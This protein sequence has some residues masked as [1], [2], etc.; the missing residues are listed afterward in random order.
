MFGYFGGIATALLVLDLAGR[1]WNEGDPFVSR[2]HLGMWFFLFFVDFFWDS[3]TALLPFLL[4]RRAFG[5]GSFWRSALGGVATCGLTLLINLWIARGLDLAPD[6]NLPYWQALANLPLRVWPF[7]VLAGTTGGLAYW[8]IERNAPLARL[9]AF[10][11]RLA[12]A[13]EALDKH[14]PREVLLLLARWIRRRALRIAG[15]A[16]VVTLIVH[17]W[18]LW[19][20]PHVSW[21]SLGSSGAGI[22]R[23]RLLHEI[24][25]PDRYSIVNPIWAPSGTTLAGYTQGEL[26]VWDDEGHIRRQ[27]K[28]ATPWGLDPSP[29]FIAGGRQIVVTGGTTPDSAFSVIDVATGHVIHEEPTPKRAGT[30][31]HNQA[32]AF[33][34]P[35]DGSVLAVSAGK[36]APQPAMLYSTQ[37][38]ALLRILDRVPLTECCGAGELSF[39][40]S[41]K[42]LAIAGLD[43]IT[44]VD[45]NTGEVAQH[46]A[47][48]EAI[49][50]LAF[51]ADGSMIAVFQSR[52][53]GGVVASDSVG[54]Y[55][56]A[57]GKEV[58]SYAASRVYYLAWDPLGRFLAFEEGDLLHLWN[59]F[60]AGKNEKTVLLR[61]S[62]GITFTPD[63]SRMAAAN[64]RYI[65]IFAI[66]GQ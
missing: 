44:I 1:A 65:S 2:F 39:D 14:P 46:I 54:I 22:P 6:S 59:P 10:L 29:V 17:I 30:D 7:L 25:S 3:V 27:V 62:G 21:L 33:A 5:S 11:D 43:D 49:H 19:W 42:R 20:E 41:G 37:S 13:L 34:A 58:A 66:S 36:W 4:I 57:D 53:D 45:P 35:P 31:G 56:V 47:A 64:D 61:S 52:A 60:G 63:G 28:V 15:F 12:A 9:V 26:V 48:N 16:A 38:W 23:F 55:R 40:R 8:A 50:R 24:E 32:T 18:P 51:S